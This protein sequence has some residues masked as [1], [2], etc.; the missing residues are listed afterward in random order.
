MLVLVLASWVS[1]AAESSVGGEKVT[2]NG[3]EATP[4]TIEE[5]DAASD[6]DPRLP[7]K[8]MDRSTREE[9]RKAIQAGENPEGPGSG[10]SGEVRGSGACT[11]P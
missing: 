2:G 9:L 11:G 5:P 3:R 1:L 10:A 8:R 4:P 6:T 7:M